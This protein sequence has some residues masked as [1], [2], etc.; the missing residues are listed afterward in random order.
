MS[1]TSLLTQSI[2]YWTTNVADGFGGYSYNAPTTLLCRYQDFVD[3]FQDFE[4]E[5]FI[6][7]AIVYTS[8][9]LE[10]NAWVYLG[11]SIE[12]NPQNQSGAYRIRNL[13]KSQNPSGSIIVYKNILG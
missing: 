4:G 10:Q 13:Q 5:E 2:T 1:Y 8:T 6:S 3:N 9:E 7:S 12:T 11:T